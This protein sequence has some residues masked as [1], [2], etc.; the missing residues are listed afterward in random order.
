MIRKPLL[1]LLI[2]LFLSAPLYG[3]D[4][5]PVVV[6]EA[7]AYVKSH[8]KQA[9]EGTEEHYALKA[10]DQAVMAFKEG[11][12]GIG[13]VVLLK[14][15][16]KVH[17]FRDRNAMVTG[18]R[19]RDHA[20]ARALD[21]AVVLFAD[22]KKRKVSE[23]E[24]ARL[25]KSIMKADST[26]DANTDFLR[27]LPDGLHVYGTLEP[28][29]MCMV[30]MLNLGVQSSTSLAKDGELKLVNGVWT[31]DGAAIATE[32]KIKVAPLIWQSFY[33]KQG[34]KFRLY[35]SNDELAKLGLRIFLET[36]QQIDDMLANQNRAPYVQ[37]KPR[38]K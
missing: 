37:E 28:C 18:Y 29:P 20:E 2:G 1:S 31:S 6:S 4:K 9:K 16:G 15:E 33:E 7:E 30:M 38:T 10:L 25:G 32:D 17:E 5:K 36:R 34:L 26:Y 13:A 14:W 23:A 35:K 8:N 24:R 12:Y 11:N 19:L 21:R 3:Q 22:L 27:K